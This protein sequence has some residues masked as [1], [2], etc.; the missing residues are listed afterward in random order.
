MV[1]LP[2]PQEGTQRCQFHV[3]A[4]K[5]PCDNCQKQF[6]SRFLRLHKLHVH[7]GVRKGKL[8]CP[9]VCGK[10]FTRQFHLESH[11]LSEHDG[12]RAFSC[13]SPDCGKTFA[14]K[15]SLWRHNVVH[16]PERGKIKKLQSKNKQPK[17]SADGCMLVGKLGHLK[18]A[19]S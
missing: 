4:V 8:A 9:R 3:S 10:S 13:V 5:V 19:D 1:R 16:D 14:M 7:L 17:T 2:D 15:E 12:V 18:L 11:V 6:N